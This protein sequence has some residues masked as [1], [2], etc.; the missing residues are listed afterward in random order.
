MKPVEVSLESPASAES[1]WRVMTDLPNWP[2]Y[3]DAIQQVELVSEPGPFAVGTRW[4]ET[5]R[6]FGQS[7]VEEM[8]VTAL[9]S[10]RSYTVESESRGA[11]YTSVFAVESKGSGA[12]LTV[13]FGAEPL[14]T[15]SRLLSSLTG[16]LMKNGILKALRSDAADLIKAATDDTTP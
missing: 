9:E 8:W 7:A 12:V 3:V 15:S 1:L 11:H 5:R 16:P 6:V 10:G 4:R 2:Q 14:S 13:T